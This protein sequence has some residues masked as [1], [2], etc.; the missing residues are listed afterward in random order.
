[1]DGNEERIMCQHKLNV[2]NISFKSIIFNRV[3]GRIIKILS[4]R[5]AV[6]LKVKYKLKLSL[7]NVGQGDF[8]GGNLAFIRKEM[9]DSTISDDEEFIIPAIKKGEKKTITTH[10]IV[11]HP[12]INLIWSIKCD[13]VQETTY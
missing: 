7:C 2:V 5:H 9:V 8:P 11:L 12:I 6:F 1:M 3:A 13:G 4:G 10:I